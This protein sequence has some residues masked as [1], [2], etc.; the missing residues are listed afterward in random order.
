MNPTNFPQNMVRKRK[1]ATERQTEHNLMAP[2]AKLRKLD[3]APGN[4][5]KER[6]RIAKQIA[7]AKGV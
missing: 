3:R 2:D 6:A 4:S 5:I 7:A 1:E